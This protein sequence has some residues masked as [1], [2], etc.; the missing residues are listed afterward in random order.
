MS[1]S[2]GCPPDIVANQRLLTVRK[3]SPNIFATTPAIKPPPPSQP[4]QR[5][6]ERANPQHRSYHYGQGTQ[7]V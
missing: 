6:G 5:Q 1:V 7:K 3:G 4:P 2:W